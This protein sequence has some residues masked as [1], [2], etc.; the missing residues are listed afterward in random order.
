MELLKI[1]LETLKGKLQKGT[2]KKYSTLKEGNSI[3][4]SCGSF[5][6]TLA[7]F[8]P[9][10]AFNKRNSSQSDKQTRSLVNVYSNPNYR[11]AII[12]HNMMFL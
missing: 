9:Y 2:E 3:N 7:Q 1:P 4:N 6:S 11:S 10:F 8:S 12:S 5:V